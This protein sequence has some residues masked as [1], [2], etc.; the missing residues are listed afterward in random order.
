V[1][2]A[3]D[4]AE[5]TINDG[6]VQTRNTNEI[7]DA[8]G[9]VAFNLLSVGTSTVTVT[10]D[11]DLIVED[12]NEFL[13]AFNE[14]VDMVR[15]MTGREGDIG[16]DISISQVEMYL[17]SEVFSIVSD[18]TGDFSSLVEIGITTG[19]TF[20]STS[21]A[22]L[23][24]DEDVFRE[25]L[26]DDRLNVSSLFHNTGETGIA[27]KLFDYLDQITRVSGF[28][29]NRGKANGSLDRQIASLEDQIERVEQRTTLKEERLRRQFLQ[30][31]VLSSG[32]QAD[33]AALSSLAFFM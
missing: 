15:T 17:R 31:E 5:F 28:L 6:A 24:L 19:G 29:N 18:I 20:D 9:D 11:D 22:H 21:S 26:R 14:S 16:T 3:G 13:T 23:E 1:Q 30:L 2:D 12:I 25:A 7:S 27:D 10:G 32:Y 33:S 8:I 4:D